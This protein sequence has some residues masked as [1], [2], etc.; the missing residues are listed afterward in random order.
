MKAI[1]SPTNDT[2]WTWWIATDNGR[3]LAKGN[4]YTER[5]AA[6]GAVLR[7]LGL[8]LPYR[9]K[10]VHSQTLSARPQ[11]RGGTADVAVYYGSGG[12]VTYA[13]WIT[14]MEDIELVQ[15]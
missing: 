11:P 7:V 6:I 1:I 9:A 13:Q 10:G 4:E 5:S 12:K 14:L 15:R 2:D 8:E 3:T